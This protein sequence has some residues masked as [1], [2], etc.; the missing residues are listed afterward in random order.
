[1]QM[2]R[3]NKVAYM[4]GK[5]LNGIKFNANKKEHEKEDI[6]TTNQKI[7]LE[8]AYL[9]RCLESPTYVTIQRI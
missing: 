9:T 2:I 1:M 6:I 3:K 7:D 4:C 8:Q 5:K